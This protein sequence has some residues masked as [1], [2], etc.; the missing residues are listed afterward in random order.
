M[1]NQNKKWL[2]IALAVLL[3]AVPAFSCSASFTYGRGAGSDEVGEM[4]M[5]AQLYTEIYDTY[6]VDAYFLSAPEFSGPESADE[7]ALVAVGNLTNL[8]DCILFVATADDQTI[9]T[10]GLCSTVFDGEKLDALYSVCAEY[11]Q[12]EDYGLAATAFFAHVNLDLGAARNPVAYALAS[13]VDESA[14][15]QAQ[16]TVPVPATQDTP[17]D[18]LLIASEP[19]EEKTSVVKPV[20][21]CLGIGILIALLVVF[22][23][24]GS[25]KPVQK[26]RDAGEYLVDGSL[27]ITAS[28]EQLTRTETSE[29]KLQNQNAGN[30]KA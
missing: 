15:Q 5:I 10:D 11:I 14:V 4:S 3:T 21:I 26:K 23:V 7:Y 25:Y 9:Y 8:P 20:L 27:H 6:G 1:M 13:V 29:R 17:D 2:S 18:E 19:A 12:A 28:Y 30:S 24:R 16:E 22:S